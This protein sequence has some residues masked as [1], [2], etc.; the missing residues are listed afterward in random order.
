MAEANALLES[1]IRALAEEMVSRRSEILS[2]EEA[3][4]ELVGRAAGNGANIDPSR[5][6]EIDDELRTQRDSLARCVLKIQAEGVQVKDVDKGLVDF[7]AR[8]GDED[9]L[10]CWHVGEAEIGW[11]HGP[12]DGFAGR[13]PID[14][15]E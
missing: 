2:L 3:R 7:P 11:F 1:T 6:G 4:G 12:E 14:E 15:L 13:R 5:L 9:V 8:V 10:L